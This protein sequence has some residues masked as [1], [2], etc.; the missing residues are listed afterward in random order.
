[1]ENTDLKCV[2]FIIGNK[3]DLVEKNQKLREVSYEEGLAFSKIN[4]L[5]F[6]ETSACTNKNIHKVFLEM[7]ESIYLHM[8]AILLDLFI[9]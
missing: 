3:V 7:I 9:N 2:V 4:N 6:F 8:L 5:N 1:M